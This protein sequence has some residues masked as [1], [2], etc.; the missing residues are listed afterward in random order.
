MEILDFNLKACRLF[1]FYPKKFENKKYFLFDFI[2]N[3]EK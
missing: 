1:K 2:S 3:S